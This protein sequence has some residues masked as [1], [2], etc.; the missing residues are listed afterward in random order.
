MKRR[1]DVP[2][3][4]E[5]LDADAKE[6]WVLLVPLVL[7]GGDWHP[8]VADALAAYCA[9]WSRWK[10]ADQEIQKTGSIVRSPSGYPIHS[11]FLSVAKAAEA[12]M[13]KWGRLLGLT[14]PRNP[15]ELGRKRR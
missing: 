5:H 15:I 4:P 8:A 7:H 6:K 9:A 13:Q 12:A 10:K 14:G 2:D 11:P 3:P 1:A